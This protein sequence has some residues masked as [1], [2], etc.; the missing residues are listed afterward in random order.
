MSAI[1]TQVDKKILI[2]VSFMTEIIPKQNQVFTKICG[3]KKEKGF[4]KVLKKD[5]F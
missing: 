3:C 5:F 1:D 4:S 2:F